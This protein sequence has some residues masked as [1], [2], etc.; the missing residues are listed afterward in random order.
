MKIVVGGG[1]NEITS[2]DSHKVFY[3][4]LKDNKS[5]LYIPIALLD[6]KHSPNSCLKWFK[7]AFNKFDL[8]SVDMITDFNDSITNNLNKYGGIYIGGGNTYKL[9]NKI[10]T[11][12]FNKKLISYLKEDRVI[13]GGSAGAIILGKSIDTARYADTNNYP[14]L[15]THGLNV[16]D[17][18]SIWCHYQEKDYSN[19][20]Q[21]TNEG[22]KIIAIGESSAVFVKNGKFIT[23]GDNVKFF[24]S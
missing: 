1:G 7:K 9:L 5:V 19:I 22:L 23:I 20:N 11:S 13:Y 15:D 2:F 17:N 21:L 14:N 6:N 18:Y 16:L 24:E 4:Q 12:G 10:Y 8:K 3:E